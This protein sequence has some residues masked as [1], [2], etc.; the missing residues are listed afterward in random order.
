MHMH[1]DVCVEG[2]AHLV[3]MRSWGVS[4]ALVLAAY[5]FVLMLGHK[6]WQVTFMARSGGGGGGAGGIPGSGY[7][8]LPEPK[9][10]GAE[11]ALGGN[12]RVHPEGTGGGGRGNGRAQQPFPSAAAKYDPRDT[13]KVPPH[14]TWQ[15]LESSFTYLLFAFGFLLSML[16]FFMAV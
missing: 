8:V 4:A 16:T 5:S 9:G 2:L 10:G 11:A 14:L 7:A 12:H 13:L 15:A 6:R 3:N 1:H